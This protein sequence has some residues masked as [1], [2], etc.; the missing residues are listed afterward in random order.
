MGTLSTISTLPSAQ[1][2]PAGSLTLTWEPRPSGFWLNVMDT[3]AGGVATVAP[4]DGLLA[5]AA[6]WAEAGPAA[7]SSAARVT[8]ARTA[9]SSWRMEGMADFPLCWLP[10]RL[11]EIAASQPGNLLGFK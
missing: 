6:S 10:Y 5:S 11:G 2:V 9:V 1:S 8:A 3:S 7:K 4:S